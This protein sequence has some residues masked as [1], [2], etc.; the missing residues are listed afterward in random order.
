[1][2]RFD[3]LLRD[4]QWSALRRLARE[5]ETSIAELLRQAVDLFLR[6]K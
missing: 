5:R 1:M 6:Q 4:K 2:K 3:L